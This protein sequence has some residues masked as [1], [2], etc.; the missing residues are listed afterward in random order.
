MLFCFQEALLYAQGKEPIC[1]DRRPQWWPT[2][3]AERQIEGRRGTVLTADQMRYN[4][5]GLDEVGSGEGV[6]MEDSPVRADGTRLPPMMVLPLE[7]IS[8]R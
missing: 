3:W 2:P 1:P 4:L 6:G 5:F 7:A 8:R